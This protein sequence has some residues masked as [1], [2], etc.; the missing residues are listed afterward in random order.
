M[1]LS[2]VADTHALVWYATGEF[3]KIGNIARNVFEAADRK[4][5]SGIVY[6]PTIV[7]HEISS[8]LIGGKIELAEPFLRWV[9]SLEKHG[10]FV[11]VDVTPEMVVSADHFRAIAD[12]FDRLIMGCAALLDEPLMTTDERIVNSRLVQVIWD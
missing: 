1:M 8:L 6:V 2:G 4:D 11:I 10:F 5:G 9:R 7:L 3:R 12:P